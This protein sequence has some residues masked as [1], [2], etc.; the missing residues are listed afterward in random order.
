MNKKELREAFALFDKDGDGCIT[1]AELL[2]VMKSLGQA[3]TDR[4]TKEM[5]QRVDKDGNGLI[6]FEEFLGMMETRAA[7]HSKETEIRALFTAFDKD[8]NGFIDKLELKETMKQVGMDLTD[9][10]V[11][12]M[13]KVAGVAIQDRIFYEDFVKMMTQ[14]ISLDQN[15]VTPASSCVFLPND[16]TSEDP[17]IQELRVSFSMFDKDGDGQI[18]VDEV[19]ETMKML[20]VKLNAREVKI[21]VKRVDTDGDGTI[22]FE[23]FQELMMRYKRVEQ[24]RGKDGHCR[25][26]DLKETFQIF[27]KDKDGYLNALDLRSTMKQLGLK[28]SENDIHAM[29]RSVGVGPL[30]KICFNDF[31]KL[32]TENL[33]GKANRE[34]K[35]RSLRQRTSDSFSSEQKRELLPV[36]S[37]F[38]KDGD[39]FIT[40]EE[41]IQ[42]LTSM[43][44]HPSED[45]IKE[46]FHQVDLDGNNRI[47]FNEFLL[48]V[49]N[50]EKPLSEEQEIREMFNAI[51]T[52]HN[53]YIDLDELKATFTKL[54]VP[55]TDKDVKDMMKEA[56]VEGSRIFY[57]DF[58]QI[59]MGEIGRAQKEFTG[60]EGASMVVVKQSNGSDLLKACPPAPVATSAATA[61]AT[62]S[63]PGLIDSELAELHIEFAQCDKDADGLITSAELTQVMTSLRLN[64]KPDE[65]RKIIQKTDLDYNGRIDFQEFCRVM[66]QYKKNV[67][68]FHNPKTQEEEE[69]RQAFKVFDK[70][71]DGYI[72]EQELHQ[73]MKEL[74]VLLSMDDIKAM[75]KKAGC[76]ITGRIYYE[77]FVK[78]MIEE[79]HT[80]QSQGKSGDISTELLQELKVAFSMVDKDGDGK[81]TQRELMAVLSR[82]GFKSDDATVKKLISKYDTD[83]NGTLEFDEFHDMMKSKSEEGETRWER[84]KKTQTPPDTWKAF[85]VFDRNSD[86][87]ISKTELYQTMKE[88]GVK[89]SMEDLDE[90]MKEADINQDG[91]IDYAEFSKLM[92][93]AFESFAKQAAQLHEQ[94]SIYEAVIQKKLTDADLKAAFDSVDQEKTGVINASQLENIIRS[95]GLSISSAQAEVMA[96]KYGSGNGTVGFSEFLMMVSRSQSR[97]ESRLSTSSTSRAKTEQEDMRAAFKVFD[98]DGNGFIDAQELRQTMHDLGEELSERDISAMIRSADKNGDGKIDYEEFILMMYAK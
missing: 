82:L 57:E 26:A 74:G 66:K 37:V 6:D 4:E 50:Y 18:T 61:A 23:E 7:R 79:V 90:M 75:M 22:S 19:M 65:I 89:L 39:G 16:F 63:E 29:M 8:N 78:L 25:D 46:I 30:G 20:G 80:S 35:G 88:L 95:F 48:L 12:T 73:T 53:G 45:Y 11:E 87:Y 92:T 43:N 70:N 62:R 32:F 2:T 56:G 28:L 9:K 84:T 42:V 91:R 83:G 85:K 3:T 14:C 15:Q 34:T 31:C 68:S 94:K 24:E 13:M 49:K 64:V 77:E 59:M 96:K 69:T 41:V 47:D 71:R 27:D 33:S 55:L 54:G 44:I 36:F 10:D 76:Q 52:D 86:G 67:N 40:M 38:D 81:I 51:D 93:G 97:Q 58:V 60:T 17:D 21:M 5:I 72:D 1:S 98:I